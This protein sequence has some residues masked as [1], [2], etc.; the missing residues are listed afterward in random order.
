[1]DDLGTPPYADMDMHLSST[2]LSPLG[3]TLVAIA[4]ALNTLPDVVVVLCCVVLW[5][6]GHLYLLRHYLDLSTGALWS[7]YNTLRHEFQKRT[8][9]RVIRK[10]QTHQERALAKKRQELQQGQEPWH[11][12]AI[13]YESVGQDD[14]PMVARSVSYASSVD[15]DGEDSSMMDSDD[16]E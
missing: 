3:N 9:W 16:A 8:Q 4:H 7:G 6:V 1:M 10:L 15:T 12:P 14:T 2:P 5:G 13:E 11:S